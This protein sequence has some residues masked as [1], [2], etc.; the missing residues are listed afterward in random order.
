MES[1]TNEG[2]EK[3]A[4]IVDIQPHD[5]KVYPPDE[6][7]DV[8]IRRKDGTTFTN[9]VSKRG[10]LSRQEDQQQRLPGLEDYDQ[11]YSD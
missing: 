5:G 2:L 1:R 8:T 4:E 6:A 3:K 10:T 11:P 9:I 7:V